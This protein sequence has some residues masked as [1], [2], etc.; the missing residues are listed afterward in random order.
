MH[1]SNHRLQQ[2]PRSTLSWPQA[3][4]FLSLEFSRIGIVSSHGSR[5][6]CVVSWWG[7]FKLQSLHVY[8]HLILGCMIT[9]LSQIAVCNFG[10]RRARLRKISLIFISWV[11]GLVGVRLQSSG[12]VLRQ[13]ALLH[14]CCRTAGGLTKARFGEAIE[15]PKLLPKHDVIDC[16]KEESSAQRSYKKQRLS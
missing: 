1:V 10:S 16:C 12:Q 14:R 7:F 3:F 4:A 11:S 8:S 2:S 6:A 13:R 9:V 15:N 5:P